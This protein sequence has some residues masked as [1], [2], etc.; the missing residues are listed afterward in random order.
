MQFVRPLIA[1][2]SGDTSFTLPSPVTGAAQFS[3]K[4][5]PGRREWSRGRYS[6]DTTGKPVVEKYFTDGSGIV[7]SLIWA[8]GLI[9]LPED[10]TEVKEGDPVTILPF[11]ELF[12]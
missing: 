3:M 10:I 2:L 1:S 7:S 8:N 5:K 9:E 11:T 4:K 6:I 12:R